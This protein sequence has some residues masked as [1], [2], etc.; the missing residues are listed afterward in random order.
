MEIK[1]KISEEIF[2]HMKYMIFSGKWEI[3]ERLPSEQKL[4]EMFHASRISVREPLKMLKGMGLVET[5]KGA[6]TY[7]RSFNADSLFSTVQP[8]FVQP[9]KK[10]DVLHILELRQ[11]EIIAVGLAA[12]RA[13]EADV[14]KLKKIQMQMEAKDINHEIHLSIDYFFHMQICRMAKNPYLFQTCRLI[15]DSL[16]RALKS[17]V[18]IMGP[19]LAQYYHP[20]IINTIENGYVHEARALMEEHLFTTVE[21]V[22]EIPEDSDVFCSQ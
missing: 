8:M 16:Q 14:D 5:R 9:L 1:K 4:M 17:I 15:H 6:G 18:R 22:K 19:Q 20:K 3:G 2:E 21:A 7:V 12:E 13:D 10:Q 11:I